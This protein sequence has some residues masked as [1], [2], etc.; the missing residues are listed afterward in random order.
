MIKK[1]FV[2]LIIIGNIFLSSGCWNYEEVDSESLV[3]G[4][5]FDK[6]EDGEKYHLTA[7]IVIMEM[8]NGSSKMISKLVEID[9]FTIQDAINNMVAISSEK[10]FFSHCKVLIISSDLAKEGIVPLIDIV[11]RE[12]ELRINTDV[13]IADGCLAKDILAQESVAA[14]I[15]SYEIDKMLDANKKVLSKSLKAEAYQIIN[16]LG[17]EGIELVVP[18]VRIT[19]ISDYTTYQ[20]SGLAVFDRDELIGF[21][22]GDEAQYFLFITNNINAG[23]IPTQINGLYVS[24]EIY[25]NKTKLK[26][27]FVNN[28]L[29]MNIE[30]KTVTSIVELGTKINYIEKPRLDELINKTEKDL[31]ENMSKLIKKVQSEYNSDIFGFGKAI[32][33]QNPTLWKKLKPHWKEQFKELNIGV[34]SEIVIRDSAVASKPIRIED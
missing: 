17:S 23:V 14:P 34:K 12:N 10:L 2:I 13:I 6:A 21:I 31:E 26:Q 11:L 24:N 18:V 27:D 3:A 22:D 7:E 8:G 25:G 29:V 4:I 5:A 19:E 16:V 9:G 28:E 32:Y 30:T 15:K 1:I 33:E 20:L